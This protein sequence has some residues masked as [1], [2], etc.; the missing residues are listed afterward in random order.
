[1][2]AKLKSG[3]F[4]LHLHPGAIAKKQPPDEVIQNRNNNDEA[5]IYIFPE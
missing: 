1:V 5:P 2:V 4:L 3:C